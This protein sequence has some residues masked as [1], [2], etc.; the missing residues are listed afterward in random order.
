MW[1]FWK[2]SK[3]RL[4][5]VIQALEE[6]TKPIGQLPADVVQQIEAE[7]NKPEITILPSRNDNPREMV[8]RYKAVLPS[9]CWI[10]VEFATSTY[11]SGRSST[12]FLY[13]ASDKSVL[14][15]ASKIANL[16][17]NQDLIMPLTA[18]LAEIM[19][20][21]DEYVKSTPDEFI[22]KNGQKWIKAQ[23]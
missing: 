8:R 22:D 12:S 2:S 17:I 10:E 20:L 14:F 3:E 9:G 18:S 7:L 15:T 16:V 4:Q 19:Q 23:E 13:Q 11:G 6:A 1:P 21:D 5:P